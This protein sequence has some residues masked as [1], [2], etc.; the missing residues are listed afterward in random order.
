MPIPVT[1][2]DAV[3][4]IATINALAAAGKI[5]LDE[6]GDL[7]N[8]AKSYIEAKVGLDIESQMIELRQIV[9]KLSTSA[10]PVEATVVGGLGTMPGLEGVLMPALG[11]PA[12]GGDPEA[13]E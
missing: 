10:R 1:V 2:E 8:L 7:A 12:N 6:A 4:N 3:A 5:G 11:P 13:S 9:E